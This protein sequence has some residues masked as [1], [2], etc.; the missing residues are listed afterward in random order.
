MMSGY[1]TPIYTNIEYPFV[2]NRPSV[3]TEPPKD[4]TAYESRNPVGSYVTFVEVTKEMLKQ[5]L[6]LHFGGVHSAFYV[7]INGQEVG[8][9]QNSMTPAEFDVTKYMREG[10]NRL[11]WRCIAGVTVAIWR[12][13]ICGVY[14]ASIVPYSYG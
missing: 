7:W 2:R 6:I 3:T 10:K 14:R 8:Y 13:R 9:S 1:G 12:I 4:W 5:N 11:A